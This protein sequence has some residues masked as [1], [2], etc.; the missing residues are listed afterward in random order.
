MSYFGVFD[1]HAGH[2]AADYAAKHLHL[3]LAERLSKSFSNNYSLESVE[4][5]IKRYFGESFKQCDEEFLKLA[6]SKYQSSDEDLGLTS[7]NKRFLPV[8]R[9]GRTARPPRLF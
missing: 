1:G 8:S 3:I 6:A 5:E 7:N 9:V 2:R 4:K